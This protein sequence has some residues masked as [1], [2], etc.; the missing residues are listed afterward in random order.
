VVRS[1][2]GAPGSFFHHLW[3]HCVIHVGLLI[4]A[5][6][7]VGLLQHCVWQSSTPPP[8]GLKLV[9]W[10]YLCFYAVLLQVALFPFEFYIP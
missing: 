6:V 1:G 9:T 2:H 10:G 5:G 3:L 8:N 4:A 7:I